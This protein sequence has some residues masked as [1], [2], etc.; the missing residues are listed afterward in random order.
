MNGIGASVF[1]FLHRVVGGGGGKKSE[2][3][4]VSLSIMLPFPRQK[5][6]LDATHPYE[7]ISS[8]GGQFML[9]IVYAMFKPHSIY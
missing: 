4:L 9:I 7:A 6:Q 2:S 5:K 8:P 3:D 1:T